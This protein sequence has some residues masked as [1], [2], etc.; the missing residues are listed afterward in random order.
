VYGVKGV[1]GQSEADVTLAVVVDCA[2]DITTEQREGE[3]LPSI[4][5]VPEV[6]DLQLKVLDID[7]RN[8]GV[9]GGWA[10]EQLGDNSRSTVNT[11]LNASEDR[12][13]RDLRKKIEKNKER[14]RISTSKLLG[15]SK[16]KSAPPQTP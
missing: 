10:A 12:I 15:V 13:L 3:L 16:G 1:N 5:I 6:N 4:L 2:Y 7:T 9:V 11:I 14:L 8:V